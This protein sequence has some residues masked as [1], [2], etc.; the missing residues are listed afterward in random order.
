MFKGNPGL[1]TELLGK[2]ALSNEHRHSL[3]NKRGFT[4]ETIDA[5]QFKSASIDN[6]QIIQ[7]MAEVHGVSPMH[8]CGL[9]N[10]EYYPSY[11]FTNPE[12]LIIPYL[13]SHNECYFFKSHRRGNMANMGV[14]PYCTK[15]IKRDPSK[16][17]VVLCESEFKAAAM[18]QMGWNAVGL[19]GVAT[20]TAKWLPELITFLQDFKEFIIL[21]DSETQ[22]NKDLPSYK[23][24]FK[25]RYAQYIFS[26]VM[27][28]RIMAKLPNVVVKIATLPQAWEIN[29]KADIDS[30]VAAGKTKDQF[31]T[32]LNKALFPGQYRQS[33]KI[34]EKYKGYVNRK[35]QALCKDKLVEVDNNCY[36]IIQHRKV[37]GDTVPMAKEI[38]N[39]VV[40][41]HGTYHHQGKIQRSI[42]LKSMFGDRSER[43]FV[44]AAELASH[45]AFKELCLSK[46]DYIYKGNDKDWL[47]LVEQLF[48]DTDPTPIHFLDM[49]GRNDEHGIWVFD[50]MIIKDNGEVVNREEGEFKDDEIGWKINAPSTNPL[51]RLK[52]KEFCEP[53]FILKKFDEA[54]GLP[55]VTAM[56]Y[57]IS[58]IFSN[59]IFRQY[60]MFPF[61]LIYGE[62]D[63]GKSTLSDAMMSLF[64]FVPT[65]TAMN[66]SDTTAVAVNKKLAFYHSL[67]CRFDEFR[68]GEKKIDD[69]SSILRSVYNRQK[70]SKGTRDPFV[71]RE[72]EPKAAFILIGEQT[73]SDPA[74]QSRFIPIYL[75]RNS[76]TKVSHEA[77]R[78]F[79]QNGNST[80]FFFY[81]L[82]K[83]YKKNS[84]IFMENV[85]TFKTA[86]QKTSEQQEPRT[87]LHYAILM[88][89]LESF[90]PEAIEP[91][92]EKLLASMKSNIE[93]VSDQSTLV[94]FWHTIE[95]MFSMGEQVTKYF[96]KDFND[97]D[98]GAI[99][100][101]G[102]YEEF[103]KFKQ[104]RGGS[105]GL[106]TEATLK[107]YFMSQSCIKHE[108]IK[109][110]IGKIEDCPVLNCISINLTD[111]YIPIP[112]KDIFSMVQLHAH[113]V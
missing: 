93:D 103:K 87:Q 105:T 26:F 62:K 34:E 41:T 56:L 76:R 67:P 74:L 29:G 58:T 104:Q 83:D 6:I 33:I 47:M 45:L 12:F 42:Q 43:F 3:I 38:T 55:G 23:E 50:N 11:P 36:Y 25:N 102:V 13:D 44:T 9:L 88:A 32:V 85:E 96:G 51:P 77:M 15:L 68:Q 107:R 95:T 106:Q 94:T 20:F 14:R 99:Y 5:L 22:D 97:K 48:L 72:V 89:A 73:P 82:I 24:D 59:E 19:G 2:L 63:S 78:W 37:G 71:I 111:P 110:R 40:E 30:C 8:Q 84:E 52:T 61:C 81:N 57:M 21:F 86:L 80:S 64:G 27:A 60:A 4:D 100:F 39:F 10:D 1:Y 75:K 49:V 69:K 17:M 7:S 18:W 66:M 113:T 112:L 54:W 31:Q 108:R 16:K 90:K 70:A 79:Y 92:K 101:A 109:R 35:I 46:G 28:D 91:Y 53:E 65:D 98:T